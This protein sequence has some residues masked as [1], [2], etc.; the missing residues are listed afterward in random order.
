VE[1]AAKDI[2][3]RLDQGI[4]GDPAGRVYYNHHFDSAEE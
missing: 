4:F 3:H 1:T 2:F